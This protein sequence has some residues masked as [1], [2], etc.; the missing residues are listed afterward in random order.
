MKFSEVA[1]P[2]ATARVTV[3]LAKAGAL[4]QTDVTLH[5]AE[6][7]GAVVVLPVGWYVP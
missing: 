2:V 7:P 3:N 5:L 4:G 1:G 6:P